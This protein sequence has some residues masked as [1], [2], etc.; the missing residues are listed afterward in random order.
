MK[1]MK[2][3]VE[4]LKNAA[5]E[6]LVGLGESPENAKVVSEILVRADMRGISTHG[7]YLLNVISMRREGGQINIPTNP[8]V[9]LDKEAVAVVDG[10]DGIGMVA[11]NLALEIAM[12]KAEKYGVSM[13]LIRNAN[14]VGCLGC[15]TQRAAENGKIAIMSSN[16]APAMAPWGAAEKFLGTNPIA[17][18]IPA[19]T[20]NFTAD[21]ATSVVARGKIREA[22]R[23][24]KTI[25]DNWA[26]DPEGRPTTDPAKA[27]EGSLMPIGGPKG[28]SLAMAVDIISGVL[29]GS[30]YGNKLKSFHV[31]E[32]P[33]GVGASCIV[34]DVSHFMDAESFKE[35]ME[36][37]F[38]TVK[39]LKK[40]Q[41][42]E[43]IFIPGEIE[44]RKEK[45]S[46]EEGVEVSDK[47]ANS[48]NELLKKVGSNL[49]I[50]DEN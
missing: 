40:A 20:L 19:K 41:G 1:R 32:G 34:I 50:I 15:Y 47:L 45:R 22:L 30:G 35:M 7:T 12:G 5:H 14:N 8:E 49:R 26:M 28:S 44:H 29:A 42:V 11:A 33:T 4:T 23:N 18:S 21:M 38:Q 17:I 48:L 13:V 39:N 3:P 2:I 9:V 37:Y 10:N 6:I 27:L 46:L 36:G 24:G 16:A 25:P 31:L 43:E